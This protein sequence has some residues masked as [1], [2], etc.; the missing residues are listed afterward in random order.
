MGV[1]SHRVERGDL[2]AADHIYTWRTA[3]TYS[4]HGIFVGGDKVVHFT[5]DQSF[6]S[7][8]ELSSM[9]LS[10]CSSNTADSPCSGI[11]DCGFRKHPSGVTMS[12][13]NCFLGKGLLHRFEYG[14]SRLAFI[15]KFR[16]GTCTTAESDP[17]AAVIHRA[18]YLLHNGF[19]NYHLF[20]NNC[21]DFALYCKTGLLVRGKESSGQALGAIGAPLAAF[22]SV[23]LKF[24]ASGPVGFVA[25]TAA[26]YS[27]SRYACDIGV[28]D[29]AVKV[30]VEDIALFHGYC[31]DDNGAGSGSDLLDSNGD[32]GAGS[33]SGSV[34]SNGDAD[35]D[36]DGDGGETLQRKRRRR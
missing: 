16:G 17:S 9:F 15:A 27:L 5:H 18:M 24:L 19:G 30:N 12:C 32:C 11:P 8:S 33:G 2:S 35:A 28:R 23:P 22:L 29:D 4:H 14:A 34:D 20:T 36:A 26:M 13:L 10:S 7:P 25:A 1:L 31:D 6:S 21:E 3:F